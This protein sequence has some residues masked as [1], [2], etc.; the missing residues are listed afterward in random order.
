MNGQIVLEPE[1]SIDLLNP[2]V[3]KLRDIIENDDFDVVYVYGPP[4]TGKSLA[5][6]ILFEEADYELYYLDT[7]S[8]NPNEIDAMSKT[9]S[10]LT[11]RNKRI[12]VVDDI[13]RFSK[14]AIRM[15]YHGDW[16]VTKLVLIGSELKRTDS[17]ITGLS[18]RFRFKKIKFNKFSDDILMR[19]LTRFFLEERVPITLEDK[20]RLVRVSDGDIRK[21]LMLARLYT[22]VRPMPIDDVLETMGYKY[23]RRLY[24]FFSND[25]EASLEEIMAF[26][27]F[28]SAFIIFENLLKMKRC[29]DILD[30]F[31][32]VLEDSTLNKE[33]YLAIIAM[34]MGRR[35]RRG[36]VFPANKKI[37]MK[38]DKNILASPLKQYL[39]YGGLDGS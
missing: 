37:K 19:V 4:G 25:F 12:V 39:Y 21:L 8:D 24:K 11:E 32:Q 29:D 33:E 2:A 10:I 27:W 5:V 16:G 1:F 14:K 23:Q 9:V 28:Y 35:K 30:V 26:G 36:W 18:K 31:L 17:H 13:T 34:E 20:E 7:I 6:R 3:K 38:Y 15:L 22:Y